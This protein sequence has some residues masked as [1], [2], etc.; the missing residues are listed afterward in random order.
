RD[1][2]GAKPS[3][4]LPA[5]GGACTRSQFKRYAQEDCVNMLDHLLRSSLRREECHET[6]LCCCT[7]YARR[8]G[9][10]RCGGPSSSCPGQGAYL[11]GYGDGSDG[12][13]END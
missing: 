9:A 10:C 5:G 4:P 12:Y 13:Q 7:V 8:P 1:E 3:P 6:P 2:C 11:F